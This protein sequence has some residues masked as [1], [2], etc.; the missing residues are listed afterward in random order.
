MLFLG[1]LQ[2]WEPHHIPGQPLPIPDV[3]KFLLMSNLNLPAHKG[4]VFSCPVTSLGEESD[5]HLAP[6]SYQVELWGRLGEEDL[7]TGLS[8]E[9]SVAFRSILQ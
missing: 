2:G 4:A 8:Q 5:P 1:H 7:V 3:T 9:G 6:T